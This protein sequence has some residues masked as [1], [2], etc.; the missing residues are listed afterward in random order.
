MQV[1]GRGGKRG[2]WRGRQGGVREREK[3]EGLSE[4]HNTQMLYESLSGK[5]HADWPVQCVR[6]LSRTF[7]ITNLAGTD[8]MHQKDE[9]QLGQAV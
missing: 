5:M 4:E 3:E 6:P 8:R 1:K 9:T 7:R 2:G